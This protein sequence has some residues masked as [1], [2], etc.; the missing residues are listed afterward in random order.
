MPFGLFRFVGRLIHRP[1][2]RNATKNL[3]VDDAEIFRV[4]A[5]QAIDETG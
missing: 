2:L 5:A 4:R 3:Y 1:S